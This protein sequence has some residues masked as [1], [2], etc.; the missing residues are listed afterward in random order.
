MG[1]TYNGWLIVTVLVAC[2]GACIGSFLNV[3]IYRIPLDQSV[4]SPRSHCMACGTPIAWYHNIPVI[5]YFMVRGRCVSCKT[6]FSIRYALVEALTALLFVMVWLCVT[7][8][9]IFYSPFTIH[10]SSFPIVPPLGMQAVPS[11]VAVP[12]YWLILS[13]LVIATFVDFDHL[14]IPDSVTW[15]GIIAGLILS[16]LL[17]ELHGQTVWWKGLMFS[18]IGAVV[19]FGILEAIALIGTKILKKEAMGFGDVKLMGAV[20]AFFGWQAAI[21]VI[22]AGSLFGTI[23]GLALMATK[24]ARLGVG[25]PF[26][27]YL[28][29]ATV[30]WMFWGWRI[31]WAYLNFLSVK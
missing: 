31:V 13:G 3:C 2:W 23:G 25:I 17:P 27:P 8:Q 20:G 11:L 14:I 19:G 22:V 18:A 4:V 28:A 26:G 6:P 9:T 29:L 15:G 7:Q 5:R 10:H 21:F 30:V 12:V 1:L 16:P 24:R